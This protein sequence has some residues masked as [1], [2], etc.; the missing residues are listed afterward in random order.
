[1][2]SQLAKQSHWK[3]SADCTIAHEHI[4]PVDLPVFQRK[5][6]K[7]A[8]EGKSLALILVSYFLLRKKFSLWK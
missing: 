8:V 5:L 6:K 4:R 1:M 3:L 2:F 7:M